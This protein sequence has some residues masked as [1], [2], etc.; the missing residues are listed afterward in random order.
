MSAEIR[1]VKCPK[2]GRDKWA[3]MGDDLASEPPC[4]VCQKSAAPTPST[5]EQ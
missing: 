5:E 4:G 3:Y 2:C 1:V